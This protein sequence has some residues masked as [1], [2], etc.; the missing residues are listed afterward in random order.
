[1]ARHPDDTPVPG[2]LIVRLDA[3]VYYANALTVRDAVRDMIAEQESPPR[4]VVLDAGTQ[5][6]VDVTSTEVVK[7]LVKQLREAGLDVYFA[8]VHAPIL[9]RGR[10][11]GLLEVIGGD[12]VFPTVDAAVRH[13]EA[14]TGSMGLD[15]GGR[16]HD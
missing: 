16:H 9:E 14:E 1:V 12:C 11:T 4:A 6:E 10:Q 2:V 8:D 7:G 3:P 13:I 15:A 5:D